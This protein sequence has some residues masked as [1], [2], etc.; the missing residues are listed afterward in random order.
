LLR[1]NEKLKN[2]R[3][4]RKQYLYGQGGAGASG[5]STGTPGYAGKFSSN[6]FGQTLLKGCGITQKENTTTS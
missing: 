6:M 1:E 5:P 4:A 3:G 2:D